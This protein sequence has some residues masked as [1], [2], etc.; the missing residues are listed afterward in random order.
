MKPKTN[1]RILTLVVLSMLSFSVYGINVKTYIPPRAFE[2][3][4]IVRSEIDRLWPTLVEYNYIPSLIEHESCLSLT[5]SRCWSPTSRLKTQREEGAGLGQVTRTWN[6]DGSPRFD[7]LSD[8]RRMY[9]KELKEVSWENIYSRPDLQIR[10]IILHLKND[11]DNL[12][13]FND[14]IVRLAA[15]DASY[16]GGRGAVNYNRRTCGLVKGCDVQQWFGHVELHSN[17]STKVLYGNRSARQIFL[18]HPRDVF[19]NRLPKYKDQ[20]FMEEELEEEEVVEELSEDDDIYDDPAVTDIIGKKHSTN[21]FVSFFR[22]LF[23]VM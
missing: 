3:K 7:T 10:M 16:N 17:K 5:H 14:P 1:H 4:E 12:Y 9:V 23:G 21:A 2:Y 22:K 11:Y 15:T 20:Y 19:F 18:D 8:M 6:S 13:E